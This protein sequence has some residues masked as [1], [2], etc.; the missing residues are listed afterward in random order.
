MLLNELKT[1]LLTTVNWKL[2]VGVIGLLIVIWLNWYL[3]KPSDNSTEYGRQAAILIEASKTSLTNADDAK[4]QAD[5]LELP[6]QEAI[7]TADESKENLDGQLIINAEARK[8]YEKTKRKTVIVNDRNLDDRE[9]ELL[10]DLERLY[11]V[12]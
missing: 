1:A 8:R 6:K 2:I 5:A 3:W 4:A 7:K 12:Q 9:R 11:P 10:T